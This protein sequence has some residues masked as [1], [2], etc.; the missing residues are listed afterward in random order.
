MIYLYNTTQCSNCQMR[1]I[2]DDSAKKTNET[3]KT[4]FKREIIIVLKGTVYRFYSSG[5]RFILGIFNL[6]S[7]NSP[8]IVAQQ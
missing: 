6:K 8:F 3:K 7:G 1:T 4:V 5:I 2:A